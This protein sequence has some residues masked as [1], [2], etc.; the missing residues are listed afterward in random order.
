MDVFK[1]FEVVSEKQKT[2][3]KLDELL[4]RKASLDK[5]INETIV[6][7]GEAYRYK[8]I[9][10]KQNIL[11]STDMDHVRKRTNELA[12]C[13]F[14]LFKE[15]LSKFKIFE[16]QPHENS[17]KALIEKELQQACKASPSVAN[18]IYTK[19]LEGFQKWWKS[20][21]N[22][23]WLGKNSSLWQKVKEHIRTEINEITKLEIKE[24]EGCGTLSNDQ[25]VQKLSDV[26]EQSTVLNIVTNPNT[27]VLQK[28]KTHL[29]LKNLGYDNYLFIGIK[30][31]MF[32]RTEIKCLWPSM[33]CEVLVV[34]CG[35]DCNV[36][37][38]VLDTLQRSAGFSNSDDSTAETLIN[39]LHKYKQKLILISPQINASE[40]HEELRNSFTYFEDNQDVLDLDEQ[41]QKQI[42][43]TPF[44]VQGTK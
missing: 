29:A 1:F 12:E 43:E 21:G 2:I 13:D 39:I 11:Q 30:S 9:L 4:S 31:L 44:N 5:E 20:M 26:I 24:I 15:F 28:R 16:S 32:P 19:Y 3:S 8:D 37:H 41:S 38:L 36:A 18:F 42:L 27:H 33:W 22:N 23:V 6:Q 34:D 7:L 17:F 35:S 40:F 25:L 14:N 10:K